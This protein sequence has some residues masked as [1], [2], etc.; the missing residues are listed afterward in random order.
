MEKIHILIRALMFRQDYRIIRMFLDGENRLYASLFVMKPW[1]SGS[2]R[3]G[4]YTHGQKFLRIGSWREQFSFLASRQDWP[5]LN[6]CQ[7]QRGRQNWLDHSFAWVSF[8][9]KLPQINPPAAELYCAYL[10]LCLSIIILAFMCVQRRCLSTNIQITRPYF[11]NKAPCYGFMY[12][13][14]KIP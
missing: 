1:D 12:R 4:F 9:M 2:R 6:R 3:C 14:R 7:I 13:T 5:R 11:H 10:R 8:Q